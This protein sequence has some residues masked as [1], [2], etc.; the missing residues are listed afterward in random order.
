MH[1]ILVIGA[2]F[3]DAELGAGGSMA[4]W[5]KEG[6]V[7]YK[8]TLSDNV[9][10]FVKR[11]IK[12]DYSESLAESSRASEILGVTELTDFPIQACTDLK[13]Q[14]DQ[15]QLIE[16]FILDYKIDTLVMHN[17][18]DIQQDHV[19]AATIS[20]VAGRYCDNVLMY[21]SNKY[22]L[23][24]DY[25]PRYYVDITSTISLKIKAL[26]CY[27]Y[28]HNRYKQLFEMTLKQNRVYGYQCS[29]G[30]TDSFAEAFKIL[31]FTE[32]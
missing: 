28:A 30:S 20:Y 10:N 2:H 24:T 6:K 31:K 18:H 14:K 3:D 23:P 19:H 11:N 32:R 4:K 8:L 5:R 21:Q 15:M 9:T 12:V 25:Y 22:I 17:I 7:V 26:D 29:M 13:F 1:N 16:S 27:G